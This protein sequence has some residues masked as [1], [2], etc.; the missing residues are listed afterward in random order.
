MST[1]VN[2]SKARGY[3]PSRLL[4]GLIVL[5]ACWGYMAP[6]TQAQGA[7]DGEAPGAPGA[8]GVMVPG[9]EEVVSLEDLT[10]RDLS[11]M[12]SAW[13]KD[14]KKAHK[15]LLGSSD[16]KLKE[17]A[18]QNI[19][20]FAHTYPD[21]DFTRTVPKLYKIYRYDENEG[22][23]IMA[24]AALGTIGNRNVMERLRED[25]SYETSERIRR[26]TLYVLAHFYKNQGGQ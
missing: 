21:V 12:S 3:L 23:R 11:G 6:A 5:V 7:T 9:D 1:Q 22:Y 8:S 14:L 25:V 4:M 17:R 18:L 24:L 13:W 20:Y 26:Q 2:T 15:R 10:S 19:I 16:A